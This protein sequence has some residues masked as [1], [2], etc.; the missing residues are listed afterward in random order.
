M[1]VA[2]AVVLIVALVIIAYGIIL[3]FTRP[4]QS[5]SIGISIVVVTATGMIYL[6]YRSLL[7]TTGHGSGNLSTTEVALLRGFESLN[8]A[9]KTMPRQ[10]PF[11]GTPHDFGV[12]VTRYSEDLKRNQGWSPFSLFNPIDPG[13]LM[14]RISRDPRYSSGDFYDAARINWFKSD[15]NPVGV[16]V[17][18]QRVFEEGKTSGGVQYG[19]VRAYRLPLGTSRLEPLPKPW[20]EDEFQKWWELLQTALRGWLADGTA[21]RHKPGRPRNQDDDWAYDEVRDRGRKPEEVYPEW[22]NRIGKRFDLLVDPE[23]TF[24]HAI[25]TGRKKLKK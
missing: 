20:H 21:V 12:E 4:D 2:K 11:N 5:A 3:P 7:E 18:S 13:G 17:E 19:E 23:D 8:G 6:S 25:K 15:A 24:R 10:T 14:A 9:G 1:R 22:R 16:R